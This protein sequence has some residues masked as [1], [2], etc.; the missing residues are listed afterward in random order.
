MVLGALGITHRVHVHA[1]GVADAPLH[2]FR[3]EIDEECR[4]LA[5]SSSSLGGTEVLRR[6]T[7]WNGGNGR[8]AP[9]PNAPPTDRRAA[10]MTI[11]PPPCSGPARRGGVAG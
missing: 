11:Q 1:Q 2:I 4:Q 9:E 5:V 3:R 6:P 8:L 7:S 10:A